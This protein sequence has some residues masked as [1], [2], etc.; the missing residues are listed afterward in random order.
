MR[1]Q[2]SRE[3]E[4]FK[5]WAKT[6]NGKIIE[7]L[8]P[9]AK[10]TNGKIII[11]QAAI[12]CVLFVRLAAIGPTEKEDLAATRLPT[13]P[14]A[15][16]ATIKTE[17][18]K[19]TET[20]ESVGVSTAERAVID[21]INR[22]RRSFNLPPLAPSNDLMQRKPGTWTKEIDTWGYGVTDA[23]DSWMNYPGYRFARDAILSKSFR[24]IGVSVMQN[25]QGHNYW[26][27]FK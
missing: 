17:T 12:I 19:A 6:T 21:A 20:Q 11:V 7:R 15:D 18:A 26:V 13:V 9:W 8:R 24:Q 25:T 16:A 4:R 23:I 3:I 1:N 14:P 27:R 10:T 2:Y 5:Q 22:E